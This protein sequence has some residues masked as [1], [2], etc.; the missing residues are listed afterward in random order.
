MQIQCISLYLSS[1]SL[2]SFS[3]LI[4]AMSLSVS[5]QA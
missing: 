4:V 1:I 3:N 2:V 5:P